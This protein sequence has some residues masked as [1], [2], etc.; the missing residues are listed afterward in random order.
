MDDCIEKLLSGHRKRTLLAR[1]ASR[2]VLLKEDEIMWLIH[3]AK[4]AFM[5]EP[6]LLEN[7]KVPVKICGD[8]HGS[9]CPPP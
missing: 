3:Q 5:S 1:R 8:I 2:K 6:T 9:P 4:A 7:V